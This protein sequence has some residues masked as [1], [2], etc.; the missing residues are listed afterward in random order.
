MSNMWY[1]KAL[2]I[3]NMQMIITK[4]SCRLGQSCKIRC[5][6][7]IC[8]GVREPCRSKNVPNS[9]MS[10]ELLGTA[11]KLGT[12]RSCVAEVW[13]QLAPNILLSR[14]LSSP[15]V[16]HVLLPIVWPPVCSRLEPVLVIVAI[17]VGVPIATRMP[18]VM[19]KIWVMI[20]HN[21][22]NRGLWCWQQWWLRQQRWRQQRGICVHGIKGVLVQKFMGKKMVVKVSRQQ[23]FCLGYK[24]YHEV[25]ELTTKATKHI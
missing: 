13:A 16:A 11:A 10:R 22:M 23:R 5:D 24:T 9:K 6:V 25:F 8:A 4:I 17:V 15:Y 14:T 3:T 7:L 18:P 2:T 21:K 20:R 12:M 1:V 19:T